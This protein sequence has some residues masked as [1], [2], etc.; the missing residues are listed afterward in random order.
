MCRRVVPEVGCGRPRDRQVKLHAFHLYAGVAAVS[1][2]ARQARACRHIIIRTKRG[3]VCKV[4]VVR[5]DDGHCC[6]VQCRR[7]GQADA[8][9]DMAVLMAVVWVFAVVS[10]TAAAYSDNG[11]AVRA[12][13][14]VAVASRDD[15]RGAGLIWAAM[16]ETATDASPLV[17]ESE[18][19]GHARR[20]RQ[21][22]HDAHHHP[23][24]CNR[25]PCGVTSGRQRPWV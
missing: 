2:L 5:R 6:C 18:F 21:R 4:Q 12:I 20:Q 19:S 11:M 22:R 14:P 24:R 15:G 3:A 7:A 16:S 8:L 1:I 25:T 23:E 17:L 10:C 9:N 13:G